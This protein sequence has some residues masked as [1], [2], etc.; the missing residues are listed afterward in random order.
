MICVIASIRV[1]EGAR[2]AFLEIFNDN[3]PRVKAEPGCIEYFPAVDVDA[4]LPVQLQ[5]ELVVT[6]V[7]KWQGVDALH[8]HLASP[9]ML[10]Y[11][12]KVKDLVTEV[13][14]KVLQPV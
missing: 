7:E 6:I 14:L 1:R 10:E 4:G 2:D 8:E 12:E 13:S 5:D 3:I 9:H 11:K